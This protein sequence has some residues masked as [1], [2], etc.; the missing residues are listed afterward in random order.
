MGS[1]A[2]AVAKPMNLEDS[3]VWISR[4]A[5]YDDVSLSLAT[6]QI[7]GWVL[8]TYCW[9]PLLILVIIG[10]LRVPPFMDKLMRK[11]KLWSWNRTLSSQFLTTSI[12]WLV[13]VVTVNSYHLL[14]SNHH[15]FNHYQSLIHP[16]KIWCWFM[17]VD[18]GLFRFNVL[19]WL[20][21]MVAK[22]KWTWFTIAF[23]PCMGGQ[24]IVTTN[25]GPTNVHAPVCLRKVTVIAQIYRP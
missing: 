18:Y 4:L 22:S 25:C 5:S 19:E 9:F 3:A 12:W 6:P 2:R 13:L 14:S 16:T 20:W 7:W 11:F 23:Q 21:F 15:V 17:V 10:W 24:S 1:P 8:S